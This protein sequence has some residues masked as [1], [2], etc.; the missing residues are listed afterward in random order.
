MTTA[1]ESVV[2]YLHWRASGEP[3][4]PGALPKGSPQLQSIED[5]N[6]EDC[7]STVLLHDWLLG[8][9]DAHADELP[10]RL[11]P[12]DWRRRPLSGSPGPWRP[13]ATALLAE[14]PGSTCRAIRP[15]MPREAELAAQEAIGPAA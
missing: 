8:L 3:P 1:D 5:Y 14:T 2:A 9:R 10:A 12:R 15:P 6:R 7:I 4:Q 13:S 11:R